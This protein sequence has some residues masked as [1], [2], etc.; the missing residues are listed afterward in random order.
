LSLSIQNAS[1]GKITLKGGVP[2]LIDGQVVGR[3]DSRVRKAVHFGKCKVT[4]M[5]V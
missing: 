2:I 1:G 5:S 3:I 4:W